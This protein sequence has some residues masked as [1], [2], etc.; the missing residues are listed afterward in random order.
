MGLKKGMTNNRFGRPQG[1]P[2]KVT[3][4]IKQAFQQ[5]VE[6]NIDNLSLW[7]QRIA[8]KE[9]DK[10]FRMIIDLSEYIIPKQARIEADIAE[11]KMEALKKRV[12]DL[13]PDEL[14]EP[15]RIED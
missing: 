14:K 13:F 5:L 15:L 11:D 8:A 2:N 6:N 3:K 12:Q 1:S 10:A 9:P 7:L 4:D